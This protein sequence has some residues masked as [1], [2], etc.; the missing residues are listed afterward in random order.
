MKNRLSRR[1][2]IAG[3]GVAVTA[4][5]GGT[6]ASA[7]LTTFGHG[8]ANAS[9]TE[10]GPVITASL[11]TGS[12]R[13]DRN[14]SMQVVVDNPLDHAIAV[15]SIPVGSSRNYSV[16]DGDD[17]DCVAGSVVAGALDGN[18][19]VPVGDGVN[20]IA[21]VN[22]E[23]TIPAHGSAE[24]LLTARFHTADVPSDNQDACLGQ[25]LE[26]LFDPIQYVDQ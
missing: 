12:L 23:S 18:D 4:V 8:T 22:G 19:I 1:Q 15:T 3:I 16:G 20:A 9:I 6:A 24:Y 13:P 17:F 14:D 21:D 11:V 10:T 25:T 7:Y 2:K 26:L 5:V